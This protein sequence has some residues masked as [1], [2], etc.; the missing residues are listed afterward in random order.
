MAAALYR[1]PARLILAVHPSSLV[2]ICVICV[3]CGSISFSRIDC[4]ARA[5][6]AVTW[7]GGIT[8]C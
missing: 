2:F 6:F 8:A 4:A 5:Q 7:R 3:I 1:S